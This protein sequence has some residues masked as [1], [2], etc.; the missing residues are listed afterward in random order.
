MTPDGNPRRAGRRTAPK[1][2]ALDL[3]PAAELCFE[4]CEYCGW[5]VPWACRN[6]RDM[7]DRAVQGQGRCLDAL[8]M[9]GGGERGIEAVKAEIRHGR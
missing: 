8:Q 7:D 2:P 6:T 3:T 5:I 9:L 1:Q 4:R